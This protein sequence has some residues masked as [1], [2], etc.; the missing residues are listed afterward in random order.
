M[1]KNSDAMIK[2]ISSQKGVALLMVLWV[3]TILLVIVFSFSFMTR[4][5]MLSTASFRGGLEK[6]FIAEGAMERAIME[7]FYRNVYKNQTIE[8]EG[9]EVWQVDG[10]PYTG[11]LG[12][13]TYT[14]SIIDESGKVDINAASDVVLKNLLVNIGVPEEEADTIVDSMMDWKDPDDL[15]RLHGAENDYYMSLQNPYKAKNARFDSLE[16][17]LLVK[18][19]TADILYGSKERKGII[20]FLTVYTKKNK[21]NINAAPKEVLMAIPGMTT[22]LADGIISSRQTKETTGGTNVQGVLGENYSLMSRYITTGGSNVF[23]ID[24]IGRKENEKGAY[25]IR[26]TV[27]LA[28]TT[29]PDALP[30]KFVYYKKPVTITQ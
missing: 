8:L 25:A 16:E 10:T 5:E 22:E 30:Y 11:Q 12:N 14:V 24:A 29:F 17:L 1:Q 21:I 7:L 18:G 20:D 13:G 15:H 9:R 26:A 3:L 4:T 27:V 28:S 2:R 6:N 23:S 19:V